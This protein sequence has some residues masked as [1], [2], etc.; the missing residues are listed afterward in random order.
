MPDHEGHLLRAY[1]LGRNNEVAFVFAVLVVENDDK[2]SILE[3]SNC[4]LY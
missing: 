2:F 4:G 1:I 3:S